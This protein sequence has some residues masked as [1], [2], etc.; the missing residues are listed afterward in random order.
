MVQAVVVS[1]GIV[2]LA[3][4]F[5]SDE[6]AEYH[7]VPVAPGG[8][9]WLERALDGADLLIVPNGSDHVAML[10]ARSAVAAFVDRGGALCCFDG[11]FTRWVPGSRWVMDNARPTK[12]VRY[13][14]ETDRRGLL[15]GLDLDEINFSHGM[16]GWWACGYIEPAPGADVVLADTWGRAVMVL[17]EHTAAGP[18]V[19]TASGPLAPGWFGGPSPAGARRHALAAL[20]DNVLALVARRG[21][22]VVR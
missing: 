11:W 18:I 12:D 6:R 13:H 17:D 21:M 5:A 7:L 2:G 1:N 10:H 3:D 14:V 19:L 8:A 22:A 9:G 20:Y 4:A 16:S 15:A